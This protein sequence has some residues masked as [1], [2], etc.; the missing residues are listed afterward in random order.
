MT[1]E[2]AVLVSAYTGVLLTKS[3]KDVQEFCEKLLGRPV[4]THELGDEGVLKE[5]REKCLPEIVKMIDRETDQIGAPVADLA[6]VKGLRP[7][8]AIFYK[9][10]KAED[11]FGYFHQ[12]GVNY[13]ELETGPGNFTTAIIETH[14]GCVVSCPAETVQ[15]LDW[16]E[17][18]AE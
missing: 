14:D 5:I 11:V 9:S 15:F 4:F 12:W 1:H 10:G 18:S 13:E 6:A 16:G 2:E 3:F 7:C 8:K 17:R